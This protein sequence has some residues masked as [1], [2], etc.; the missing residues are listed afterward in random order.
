[1]FVGLVFNL[2]YACRSK[3][4]E[5]YSVVAID[6]CPIVTLIAIFVD[7]HILNPTAYGNVNL[8][9]FGATDDRC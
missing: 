8:I 9:E 4:N 3:L 5:I 2:L 7:C 6:I 1:M